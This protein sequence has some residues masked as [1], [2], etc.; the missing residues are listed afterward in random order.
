MD[1]KSK[2]KEYL[3][4]LKNGETL[5]AVRKD[6]IQEFS[7]VDASLIMEAEQEL[8]KEGVPLKEV[9]RLCDVHSSL[10]HGTTHEERLAAAEQSVVDGNLKLI[11]IKGHPL[12]TFR[13]ENEAL[14]QRIKIVEENE[15]Q[16]INIL[17][18]LNIHYAKKGDLLYPLL[19]VKYGVSGPSEVMWSVDDEIRNELNSIIK[20]SQNGIDINQSK[21]VVNRIQEMIYKEN[22]ILFPICEKNFNVKE[23]IGIYYDSKDYNTCF[24]VEN[25][26]FNLAENRTPK[27]PEISEGVLEMN[28]GYLS[29]KELTHLLNTIPIEITFVDVHNRNKYFNEG[30][31]VF[32]RPSMAINRDV[33]SCHPP[34]IE[35]M[36]KSI[37]Q[38]LKLGNKDKVEI[39]MQKENK[40]FLVAYYAVRDY[41][42]NYLGTVELVQDMEFAQNYFLKGVEK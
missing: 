24:G 12:Y 21:K 26:T 1:H 16:N 35:A 8:L 14:Q 22:H 25:E 40:P 17:Q 41:Q 23:W 32:K 5:E 30:H 18:D 10:F 34:K 2:I 33:F 19:K 15:F 39:W 3:L 37:I 36:V 28:G 7:D 11:N 6:F 4:R 42:K 38:D 20:N 31:K 9:Q 27:N 29:V 13:K